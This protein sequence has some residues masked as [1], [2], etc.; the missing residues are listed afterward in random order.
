MGRRKQDQ[1]QQAIFDAE[2]LRAHHGSPRQR[3]RRA[4]GHLSDQQ[5]AEMVERGEKVR[6]ANAEARRRR[7]RAT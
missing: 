2:P 7:R 3:V 1:R 5:Y 4:Y 6:Q